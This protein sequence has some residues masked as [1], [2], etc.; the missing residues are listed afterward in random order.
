VEDVENFNFLIFH[1]LVEFVCRFG[2]LHCCW[3][4]PLAKLAPK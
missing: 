4:T 1:Q 3:P 2:D